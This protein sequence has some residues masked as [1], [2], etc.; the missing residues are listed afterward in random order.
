MK[1]NILIKILLVL[2]ICIIFLQML[3]II[4]YTETNTIIHS[5]SVQM[6]GWELYEDY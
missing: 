6:E 3:I 5:M 2:I 1:Q 4:K